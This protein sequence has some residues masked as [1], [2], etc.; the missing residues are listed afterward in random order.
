METHYTTS[1]GHQ[2]A[3]ALVPWFLKKKK[4]DAGTA[5]AG[6]CVRGELSVCLRV[7]AVKVKRLELSTPNSVLP[8]QR[9]A[10]NNMARR[11]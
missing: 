10:Q 2:R 7:R 1:Y 11:P 9:K 8:W 5:A 3:L 6:T 4:T